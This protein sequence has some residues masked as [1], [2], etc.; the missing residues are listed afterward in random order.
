MQPELFKLLDSEW[1]TCNDEI[2]SYLEDSPE[3]FLA[4]EQSI[5]FE[6][7]DIEISTETSGKINESDNSQDSGYSSQVTTTR[8][9]RTTRPVQ[10]FGFLVET[11]SSE[12]VKIPSNYKEAIASKEKELWVAAMESEMISL[13]TL[14]TYEL[15]PLP[16]GRRTVGCRWVYDLK[17]D[18]DGNILRFKARLVAQGYSQRYL[19]DYSDTYSPVVDYVTIRCVLSIA[20]SQNFVIKQSDYTT[21]YLNGKL[22]EVI[23]MKQPEGFEIGDSVCLLRKAIYGLKQAGRT[24]YNTIDPIIRKEGFVRCVSDRCM[25]FNNCRESLIIIILYVDDFLIMGKSCWE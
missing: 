7:E 23:Y 9:G 5:D 18:A 3:D 15:V 25:Y 16:A 17:T 8:S 4:E 22:E 2:D 11:H 1:S 6:N 19:I 12:K 24:W 13:K 20:I 14:G 21:A 10:R